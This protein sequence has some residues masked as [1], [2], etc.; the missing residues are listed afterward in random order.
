[1]VRPLAVAAVAVSYLATPALAQSCSNNLKPNY[2]APV[3]GDGWSYRLVAT[4]LGKPRGILV[5]D[6]GALLL[7]NRGVGIVH[8]SLKD[9]G[10][11]CLSEDKK[12]TLVELEAVSF[13][14]EV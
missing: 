1:M 10:G 7:V 14:A 6:K 5:D 4:G 3:T 9:E 8:I 11:T 13:C 12:T 2:T